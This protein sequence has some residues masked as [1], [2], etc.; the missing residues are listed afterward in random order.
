MGLTVKN[1]RFFSVNRQMS[2]PKLA[3]KFLFYFFNFFNLFKFF[4]NKFLIFN[5]FLR[6][7]QTNFFKQIFEFFFKYVSKIFVFYLNLQP[8][9]SFKFV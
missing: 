8:N 9:L 1:G 5:F 4:L 7:F 3:V 6:F 2:E